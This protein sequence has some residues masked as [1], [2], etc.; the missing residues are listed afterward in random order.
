M[1]PFPEHAVGILMFDDVQLQVSCL[2]DNGRVEWL[3]DITN[4][5]RDADPGDP[6]ETSWG[7]QPQHA[8]QLAELLV[9][10]ADAAELFSDD[11]E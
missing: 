1:E 2:Y 11:Q 3:V 7:M 10:A 5:R 6:P 4:W 8:R 9:E